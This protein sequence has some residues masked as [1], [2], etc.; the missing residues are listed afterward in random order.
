MRWILIVLHLVLGVAAVGAGQAFVRDPS[1]SDL[2]MTVESLERS[3]F[4]DFRIPGLFLAIVIG[5]ANLLSAV[6]LLRR[7]PL[8]PFVSLATG[9][10]LVVWVTIQTAIIGFLH[11]SQAIWWVIF[12]AVALLAGLLVRKREDGRR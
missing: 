2:G 5:G 12:P 4:P 6:A 10:L 3:P 8:A 7:H 1:G 11:W 9:L